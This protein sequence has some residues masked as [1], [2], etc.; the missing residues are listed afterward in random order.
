[1][2]LKRTQINAA[3]LIATDPEMLQ[4]EVA[5][6]VGVT[7]RSIQ[8][9][10]RDEEFR[11][12]IEEL[13]EEV[14]IQ[15]TPEQFLKHASP[16]DKIRMLKYLNED[17][18]ALD[19]ETLPE[20]RTLIG[21]VRRLKDSS[22][23]EEYLDKLNKQLQK[24]SG[25]I[26][27]HRGIPGYTEDGENPKPEVSLAYTFN[28]L[29]K[30]LKLHDMAQGYVADDYYAYQESP[31]HLEN[32]RTIKAAELF[33]EKVEAGATFPKNSDE[34]DELDELDELDADNS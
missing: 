11:E 6:R 16:D 28:L 24:L 15:L 14:E 32:Q 4:T 5:K 34:P 10:N 21:K 17:K 33:N 27:Y 26:E 18:E 22:K 30:E 9:W 23:D 19:K 8:L 25:I 29:A 3:R 1:M 13:R 20:I 2:P 31:K 7:T 12:K